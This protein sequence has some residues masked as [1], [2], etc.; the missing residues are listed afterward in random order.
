MVTEL[1]LSIA[2]QSTT[3]PPSPFSVALASMVLSA[4]MVTVVAWRMVP[5]PCQSPPISTVPPLVAPLASTKVAVSR[6]M[7]SPSTSTRPAW[8]RGLLTR[9]TVLV[10]SSTAPLTGLWAGFAG[11]FAGAGTPSA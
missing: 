3:C 6:V 1:A 8:P 10:L 7:S 11:L 2:L 5:P 4:L 9:K